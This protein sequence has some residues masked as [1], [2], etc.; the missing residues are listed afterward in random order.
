MTLKS[1][2]LDMQAVLSDVL[3]VEVNPSW[4]RQSGEMVACDVDLPIGTV[5]AL[6]ADGAY[7][8][9]LLAAGDAVAVGMLITP[10]Y[11]SAEKSHCVV[12]RRGCVVAKANLFYID[13]ASAA[14]KQHAA[15][16]SLEERG[17]VSQE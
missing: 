4:C 7:A 3:L 16:A 17:I 12:I 15:L 13:A 2:S 8:P 9:Y 1:A 10:V 5:V 14:D 6:R 11:A